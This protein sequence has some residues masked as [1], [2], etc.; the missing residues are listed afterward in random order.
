MKRRIPRPIILHAADVRA[1]T[2]RPPQPRDPAVPGSR[3]ADAQ[4][5]AVAAETRVDRTSSAKSATV[6]SA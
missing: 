3:D 2:R 6:C 5:S 1:D 4:S